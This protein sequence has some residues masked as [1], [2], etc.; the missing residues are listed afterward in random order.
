MNAR[1]LFLSLGGLACGVLLALGVRRGKASMPAT[2]RL[3]ERPGIAESTGQRLFQIRNSDLS[4]ALSALPPEL[5]DKSRSGEALLRELANIPG[6]EDFASDAAFLI[7]SEIL[8]EDPAASF[9]FITG[10]CPPGLRSTYASALFST[11]A[12]SD[13]EAA[14]AALRGLPAGHLKDDL[15]S[16]AIAPLAATDPRL[17]WAVAQDQ[18]G[19]RLACETVFR[20]WNGSDPEE[21]AKAFAR[22]ENPFLRGQAV[23][24]LAGSFAS[25]PLPEAMAW[26]G[27]L[28]EDL[29]SIASHVVFHESFRS[30]PEGAFEAL[31]GVRDRTLKSQL[32]VNG[33][34][35]IART[36][37][38]TAHR[39]AKENLPPQSYTYAVSFAI[40]GSFN[41]DS[42]NEFSAMI[43]DAPSGE[44][45]NSLASSLA[46]R[47]AVEDP[48][49]ARKWL[50]DQAEALSLDPQQVRDTLDSIDKL[51]AGPNSI[52]WSATGTR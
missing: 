6:G 20:Q 47:Y 39:L 34:A 31:A 36:D 29:R 1:P 21:A 7:A 11:W 30:D 43:A 33:L 24:G 14:A 51:R 40:A 17:A 22:I 4:T 28:D 44:S 3:H 10:D 19:A 15:M 49:K 32:M 25:R 41:R 2:E 38:K 27:S 13:P 12:A 42:L 18:P 26:I 37:L 5:R 8:K 48:E 45:R 23:K 9:R 52:D 46:E 35:E 16:V 50:T